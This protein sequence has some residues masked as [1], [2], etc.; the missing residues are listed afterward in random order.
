MIIQ[1]K[2]Q[3]CGQEGKLR[4]YGSIG[5]ETEDII[6]AVLDWLGKDEEFKDAL[7][8]ERRARKTPNSGLFRVHKF[9]LFRTPL[10]LP[11]T[12]LTSSRCS[13][14]GQVPLG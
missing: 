6:D 11:S 1:D 2:C 8:M 14:G 10:T 3:K 13:S 5:T 4:G 12:W 9:H 7:E